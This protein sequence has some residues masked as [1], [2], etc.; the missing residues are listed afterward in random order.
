MEGF[1]PF[2][3]YRLYADRHE[4]SNWTVG[5][6][7]R[8]VFYSNNTPI[9]FRYVQVSGIGFGTLVSRTHT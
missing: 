6:G 2:E 5:V 1:L 9:F 8:K 4:P 7:G 3:N